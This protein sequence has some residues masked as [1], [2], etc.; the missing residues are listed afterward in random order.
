M[1]LLG[2]IL[3]GLFSCGGCFGFLPMILAAVAL[4]DSIRVGAGWYWC[5]IILALPVLGPIA[6]FVVVRSPLLGS[7]G[8]A[9]LSPSAARRLQ[10]RRHLKALQVQ[11]GHWRGPGVLT[12]AGEDLLVLGKTKEAESHFREALA[13]GAAVED[14]HYGL[15][16]A[17]QVQG[18]FADAV[19]C[20]EELIKAEPDSR[21][22]EGPLALARCL[23]ESGR[24]AEAEP[25]L[26][27]V[28]ERRT[29][30]EA[31]VRLARLLL[32]KGEKDEAGRLLAE[33]AADAQHLPAYLKR[34]HRDWLRAARHLKPGTSL[35][36]PRVE[37]AITPRE[38]VQVAAVAAGALLV[39]LGGAAFFF[40]TGLGSWQAKG[41]MQHYEESQAL[42]DK[43]DALDREHPWTLGDDLASV[44]LTVAEVDRYLRVR[45][46]VEPAVQELLRAEAAVEQARRRGEDAPGMGELFSSTS[47]IARWMEAEVACLRS[48][49]TA[50]EREA[51]GPRELLNDLTLIEWR[52]LRR[53][54]ALVLGLEEFQRTDWI[55]AQ[56]GLSF[57][58]PEDPDPEMERHLREQRRQRARLQAKA[59]AL[60]EDA[61]AA[62]ALAPATQTLL[63]A[64]RTEVAAFDPAAL[65]V[66]LR[67]LDATLSTGSPYED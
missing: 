51:M 25:L 6:Y 18:R 21:L 58:L 38:R 2:S 56:Q 60:E 27:R 5:L 59:A 16:E 40:T 55:A 22:G 9:F 50:L 41:M 32:Q 49:A 36:R 8:S 4:V 46:A 63:E 20:L 28:L 61:N 62:V 11:L 1:E 3:V 19:P 31:Q 35:P 10:A 23:D 26:R 65:A 64:R 54:E 53:P 29:V 14:V 13:N 39:L 67:G 42:R 52:F 7:H 15:A 48:L 45:R 47:G 12:E 57:P 43:L 37:G 66:I 17:L 33:V 34:R 30:I 24:G 44:E